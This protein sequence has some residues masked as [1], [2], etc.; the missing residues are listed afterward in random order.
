MDVF[1]R[2]L[3]FFNLT[4]ASVLRHDV[5][6][7]RVGKQPSLHLTPDDAKLNSARESVSP[8]VNFAFHSRPDRQRFLAI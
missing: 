4:S 1:E 2:S 6:R 8:F 5:D 7:L 3:H